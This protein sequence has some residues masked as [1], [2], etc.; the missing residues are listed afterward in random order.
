MKQQ[1]GRRR[2]TGS[3]AG[4]R[5]I[6]RGLGFGAAGTAAFLAA[7]GGGEDGDAGGAQPGALGTPAVVAPTT[8][9]PAQRGGEII[10]RRPSAFTFGDP[11]RGTSG[12]DPATSQLYA[13]PLLEISEKGELQPSLVQ[14]WEQA[15]ETALT[16]KLRTDLKFA[17][18]TPFNAQAVKYSFERASSTQLATPTRRLLLGIQSIETPD[19]ATVAIKFNAP[20]SVFLDTLVMNAPVGIGAVIS[21]TAHQRLGDEKFNENPVSVGPYTCETYGRTAETVLAKNPTWPLKAPNGDALPYPDKIK[22]RVIP[23]NATAIADLQAGNIDLDYVFL[24]ENVPTVK[25]QR[26]LDVFPNRRAITQAIGMVPNKR[27]TD[28]LRVRQALAYAANREEYVATFAAGGLGDIGKGPLTPVNWAYDESA[29]TY[30]FDEKKARDLM[31]AAGL[32]EGTEL[33]LATYTSGLYPKIGEMFQAQL[34]RYKVKVIV[35]PV[36]LAIFAERYRQKGE[37]Q[38]G[39]EGSGIPL[40]DPFSYLQGKFSS[41]TGLGGQKMPEFDALLTKALATFDRTE[42]KKVYGQI[43]AQD[44]AQATRVWLLESPTLMAFRKKVQGLRWL[45]L[46]SA[47]D[48]RFAWKER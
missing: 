21:P 7:C 38:L 41:E 46:G 8:D 17:D 2:P 10:V 29:P 6:L 23:E 35:E 31:A 28:D 44:H 16:L 12:Y 15:G 36:D 45:N 19:D 18:G 4:R 11:Q 47:V 13:A 22:F 34:A 3:I 30:A 20:N 48:L 40:G 39:L 1:H 9:K 25:A 27:P 32:G 5:G 33:R 14:S 26:D 37:Y 24:S 43:Q 42:R